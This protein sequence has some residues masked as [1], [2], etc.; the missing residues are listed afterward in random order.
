MNYCRKRT[1]CKEV[2]HE[3]TSRACAWLILVITAAILLM[4]T[5]SGC[6]MVRE[7]AIKVSESEVKNAIAVR[8]VAA[9]YLSIWSIQSGFIKGAIGPRMDELPAQV[10]DAM[11]ELDQL[12]EQYLSDPEGMA[13]YELG[14]SL[15]LR[16]RMLSS[17]VA[18]ALSFYMPEAMDFAP[19]LF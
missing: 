13:D 4:I 5:L 11:K 8:E 16:V 10:V 19:F 6:A 3:Q 2:F 15:G 14:Q 18:E 12:A 17:I 1:D 7:S 9:N